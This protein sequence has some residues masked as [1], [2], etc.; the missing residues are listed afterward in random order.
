MAAAPGGGFF[1]SFEKEH[2]IA[3]Y[4]AQYA[5]PQPVDVPAAIPALQN[6]SGLEALASGPDGTLYVADFAGTTRDAVDVKLDHD[7]GK[8]LLIDTAGL[9]KKKQLRE[10]LE[11]YAAC[12]TKLGWNVNLD[13]DN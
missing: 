2:R 9:R 1:V 12:R 5:P 3:F 13:Q 4:P 6:N 8:Y 11:F 10:D 7:A